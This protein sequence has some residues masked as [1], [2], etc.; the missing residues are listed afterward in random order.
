MLIIGEGEFSEYFN[1]Y[2]VSIT[3][4]G[5]ELQAVTC[6]FFTSSLLIIL[7]LSM[8]NK[9]PLPWSRWSEKLSKM[10]N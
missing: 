9:I 4:F 6:I 10:G 3:L 1:F 8:C 5:P 7:C 2:V